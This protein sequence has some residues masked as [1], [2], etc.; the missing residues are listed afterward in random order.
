[1]MSVI[2]YTEA[3]QVFDNWFKNYQKGLLRKKTKNIE[4]KSEKPKKPIK[5]RLKGKKNTCTHI[6]NTH[7]TMVISTCWC[8]ACLRSIPTR[9]SSPDH[10]WDVDIKVNKNALSALH[11]CW[12]MP[13]VPVIVYKGMLYSYPALELVEPVPHCPPPLLPMPMHY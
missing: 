7:C 6:H 2:S 4:W 13:K 9:A 12:K 8:M 5:D 3:P 1:M 10:M 11:W